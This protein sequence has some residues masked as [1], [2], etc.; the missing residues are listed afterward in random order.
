MKKN[1]FFIVLV[2]IVVSL[3]LML[4]FEK[5]LETIG[6][7]I[8]TPSSKPISIIHEEKTDKGS[9]VFYNQLGYDGLS[10]A[11]V[12]KNIYGYK[13]VYSGVQ[14][15]IKLVANTFGVSY[16]YF[17]SIEKTSLPIY[18]GVIGNPDISQVKVIEK[19]IVLIVMLNSMV[20]TYLKMQ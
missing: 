14:G 8:T 7:A 1:M 17:P 9:I 20:R 11:F 6:E 10:T 12:K 5:S 16:Q 18:F 19:K 2:I 3:L 4:K 15:D 13:T